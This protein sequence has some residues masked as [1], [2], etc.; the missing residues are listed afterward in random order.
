MTTEQIRAAGGIVHGDGNIF[1][2]NAGQLA[3]YVAAQS[4]GAPAV[5][6]ETVARFWCIES[7]NSADW[8]FSASRDGVLKNAELMDASCV[9]SEPFPLYA[10]PPAPQQVVKE[11]D[12]PAIRKGMMALLQCTDTELNDYSARLY[13]GYEQDV[14]RMFAAF[15]A[16]QSTPQGATK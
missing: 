1:F 11:L 5:V 16:L 12:E 7:T 2:T 3:A 4:S 6:A 9:L 13:D 14:R 15:A 10:A 8:C